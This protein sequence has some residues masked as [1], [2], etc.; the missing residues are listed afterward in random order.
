MILLGASNTGFRYHQAHQPIAK[1]T[2]IE[3]HAVRA[4]YLLTAVADLVRLSPHDGFEET[5][6][7]ALIRLWDNMIEKKMYL[8]GGIGAMKQWE[9]F[10]IDYFLPQSS[11]EGGCYAE[12]CAAIGVMMLCERLLQARH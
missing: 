7:P 10:G 4:M 6:W 2:T 3:G 5:Y 1:Q 12:T 8:T 9:G 11:D